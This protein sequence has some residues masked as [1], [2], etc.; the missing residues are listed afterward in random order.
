MRLERATA[1]VTGANSGIGQAVSPGSV[2][3]AHG[4]CSPRRAAVRAS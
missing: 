4:C 3:R 2:A 1:L